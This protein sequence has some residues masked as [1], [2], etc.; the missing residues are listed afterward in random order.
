M[1][2]IT[3]DSLPRCFKNHPEIQKQ[4]EDWTDTEPPTGDGYQLWETTSEGSLSSPVRDL[5]DHV[6][7]FAGD[8]G[9]MARD[10]GR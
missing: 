7:K 5:G 1:K 8:C 2:I 9:A 3:E 4:A 10:A 6:R